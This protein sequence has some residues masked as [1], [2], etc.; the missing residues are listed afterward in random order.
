M[1]N[2]MEVKTDG[3]IA[4]MNSAN[5]N[6]LSC[7]VDAV[8][9]ELEKLLNVILPKKALHEYGVTKQDLGEFAD[10]VMENQGRLMA[11]N[12]VKSWIATECTRFIKNYSR[13][14]K[15]TTWLQ[16]LSAM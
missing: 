15:T 14:K 12:F 11:N 2:Y 8:Y 5:R 7:S 1:N 3:E 16:H 9:G 4:V 10:S 6:I 13:T